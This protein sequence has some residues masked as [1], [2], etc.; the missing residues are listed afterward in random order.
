MGAAEFAT[1]N[2]V[3]D[4]TAKGSWNLKMRKERGG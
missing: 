3:E 4:W 2:L 1:K